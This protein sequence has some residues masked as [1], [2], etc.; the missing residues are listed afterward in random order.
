MS[1][2][3]TNGR[4]KLEETL[5]ESNR[6]LDILQGSSV[7]VILVF[8]PRPSK[9]APERLFCKSVLYLFNG[10]ATMRYRQHC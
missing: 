9:H 7:G 10:R 3:E 6:G 1:N 2:K 4:Y 5:K 8:L